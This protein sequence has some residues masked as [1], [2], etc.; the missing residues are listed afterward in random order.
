MDS[1][2]SERWLVII[3]RVSGTMMLLALAAALMPLSCMAATHLWLRLGEFPEG[4]I[5]EYLARS[6]SAFY[7]IHGALFWF[8]ASDIR[9]YAPV[10]AFLGWTGLLGGVGLFALD[11][12]LGL[13]LP[14]LVCEGPFVVLLCAVILVLVRGSSGA[15]E[16]QATKGTHA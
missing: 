13:P 10:I 3:L 6:L 4:P 9:R 15:E 16:G 12:H 1:S 2:R 5:V 11:W 14:W 8:L 7:A